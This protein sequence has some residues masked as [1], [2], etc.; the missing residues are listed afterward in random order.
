MLVR[1]GSSRVSHSG[2]REPTSGSTAKLYTGVGD[3]T[4]HSS[5]APPHGLSPA[6]APRRALTS[7]LTTNITMPMPKMNEPIVV[8]MFD[9]SQP[10]PDG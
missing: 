10:I 9:V 4:D 1:F 7:A 6:R 5:P 3:A 2:C 8:S